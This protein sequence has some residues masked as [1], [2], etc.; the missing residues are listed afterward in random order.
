[1]AHIVS[2]RSVDPRLAVGAVVVTAD[3]SQ[4]LAIGYNGQHA[5][6]PNT[7]DSKE[8][9]ASGLVHAEINAL[10]KLDFNNPQ[11]KTLYVTDTPCLHCAKCIINAGIKS[12][13]YDRRYRNTEGHELLLQSGIRLRQHSVS[14]DDI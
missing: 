4:V 13:V 8:P 12:I 1:M 2:A 9:G 10:I 11:D 7:V 14:R 6:G 5:G 3:N